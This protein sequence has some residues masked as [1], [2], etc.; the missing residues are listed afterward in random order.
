MIQAEERSLTSC[1][2]LSFIMAAKKGLG[3]DEGWGR[4][5]F[6]EASLAAFPLALCLRCLRAAA[7]RDRHPGSHRLSPLRAKAEPCRSPPAP[8]REEEGAGWDFGLRA[9]GGSPWFLKRG[10]RWYHRPLPGRGMRQRREQPLSWGWEAAQPQRWGG[11]GSCACCSIVPPW[12]P[13][14]PACL[15]P[16]KTPPYLSFF[17][18]PSSEEK[19]EGAADWRKIQQ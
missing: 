15:P 12:C 5:Q 2:G 18:S 3:K 10:R 13:H 16:K 7:S 4:E 8:G 11:K 17:N 1:C 6:W 19:L 14:H 9:L